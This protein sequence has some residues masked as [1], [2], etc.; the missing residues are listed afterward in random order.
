MLPLLD[1]YGFRGT[2]KSRRADPRWSS[3]SEEASER[4]VRLYLERMDYLAVSNTRYKIPVF[5]ET[6]TFPQRQRVSYEADIIAINPVS[7]DRIWGEVKGWRS[8]VQKHHFVAL[9]KQ[10]NRGKEENQ[11]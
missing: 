7:G 8:G 2:K 9:S 10:R 11:W 3:L 6:R 5:I 4:L 1:E